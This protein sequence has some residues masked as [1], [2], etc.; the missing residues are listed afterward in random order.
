[1]YAIH[2]VCHETMSQHTSDVCCV[3][4]GGGPGLLN[5]P[6]TSNPLWHQLCHANIGGARQS[7][8]LTL[9]TRKSIIVVLD[10]EAFMKTEYHNIFF[11]ILST[12]IQKT[13]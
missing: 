2:T 1:M 12:T 8:N 6:K 5:V 3:Y 13:N 11:S 4:G 9:L 10:F 7:K